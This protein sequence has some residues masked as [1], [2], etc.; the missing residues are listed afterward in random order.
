MFEL[1]N[2]GETDIRPEGA[3]KK[4]NIHQLLGAVYHAKPTESEVLEFLRGIIDSQNIPDEKTFWQ[5]FKDSI[6]LKIPFAVG[7]IDVRKLVS[8][9]FKK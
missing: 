1:L 9:L 4:Y 8:A 7:S 3:K 2:D 6:E 5:K